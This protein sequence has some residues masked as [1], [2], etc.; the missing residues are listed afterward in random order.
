MVKIIYEANCGMRFTTME[1]AERHE[2]AE[3]D[4]KKFVKEH[5]K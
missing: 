4:A 2:K 3:A 5:C 1:E